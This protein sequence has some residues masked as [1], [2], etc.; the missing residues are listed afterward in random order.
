MY[1]PFFSNTNSLLDF[2]TY[3]P[4]ILYFREYKPLFIETFFIGK[5]LPCDLYMSAAYIHFDDVRVHTY[6]V[7]AS[8]K[9][10]FISATPEAHH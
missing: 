8:P 10:A 1:S 4:T 6:I 7:V 2:S 9:Y 5:G 3:H